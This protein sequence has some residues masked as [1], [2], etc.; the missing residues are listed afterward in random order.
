MEEDQIRAALSAMERDRSF[1]T[2]S[3]YSA[4]ENLYPDN[5]MSFTQKHLA[6]LKAHPSLR[7]E[8]YLANLRLLIKK[9]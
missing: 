7:P 6:Y 2:K 5:V 1:N 8:H 4:N 9:R 3:S